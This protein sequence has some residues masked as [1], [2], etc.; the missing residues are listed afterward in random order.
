MAKFIN[1]KER[2]YDLKLTNYGHYLLSVGTFKPAYYSFLDD[3]VIYDAAYAG[4]TE[5][6]N[7]IHKRIKDET[8]YLES[9]V[10]F[11]DIES[12]SFGTDG[13]L[14]YF[15]VDM[16]PTVV[17]P[18]H[19]VFHFNSLIGDA[20]LDGDTQAVP[21]WKIAPLQGRISSSTTIDSKNSDRTPQINMKLIYR[22]TAEDPSIIAT[23]TPND[24][25]DVIDTVETPFSDGKQ[26]VFSAD[27]ALL[28]VE[29]VN[30]DFLTEN[31][32]LEVF[33]I[34]TG[35]SPSLKDN[36]ERKYFKRKIPQVENGFMISAIQELVPDEDL[37][38]GSVEYYFDILTDAEVDEVAACRGADVF[39][40]QSYFVDID[41]DCD[42]SLGTAVFNDIY[43]QATEPEICLD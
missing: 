27:N 29:E 2:V 5:A 36:L 25:R 26:I 17:I 19:D 18:E 30:T 28:Y 34:I 11:R 23:L 9:L 1:K 38:S 4:R 20:Y 12:S 3:N 7:E 15:E 33:E 37:T 13:L 10:L 21:A 6:Q 22:L 14:N 40:K 24:I 32:D 8:Q 31:F 39:N 35:S 43:G 41:F 42:E 16:S